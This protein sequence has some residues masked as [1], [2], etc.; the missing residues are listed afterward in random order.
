M[1]EV[2]RTQDLGHALLMR[3][4]LEAAGIEA[5]VHGQT[6]AEH[7]YA[8]GVSLQVLHDNDLAHSLSVVAEA[9]VE[10]GS[11]PE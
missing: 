5:V 11:L 1:K 4:A 10:G 2:L 3:A 7:I 8:G 9:E 6:A